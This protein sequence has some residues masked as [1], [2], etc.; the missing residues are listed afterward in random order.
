MKFSAKQQQ[1]LAWHSAD[2]LRFV[3][4]FIIQFMRISLLIFVFSFVGLQLLFGLTLKSQDIKATPV[5][6]GLNNEPIHKA[7]KRIEKQ[8]QFRF[9]YRKDDIK[10]M[11]ILSLPPAS[12]TV[13]QTLDEIFQQ[14]DFT[15]RQVE[16]NIL[17]E[18]KKTDQVAERRFTGKVFIENTKDPAMYVLVELLNKTDSALIGHGYTDTTG[19]YNI[20]AKQATAMILR[21]SGLGYQVYSRELRD[22]GERVNV[23]PVYLKPSINNLKEVTISSSKPL[24]QRKSDRFVVN[25][26]NS[27]LSINN[28]VWDVLKQVPLVN[29]DDNGSLSISAKQGAIVYINGRKSNLSGQA[30]FNYLKSLPST[31]L[32]DI[33]IVTTPGSEFDASGNAGILNI[34]FKKRES[35]GY[36]GSLALTDRQAT[37]NSQQVSGAF[38]YRQKSLGINVTPYLNRDRK[39]IAERH[40]FDFRGAATNQILNL[41]ALDR[42]EF[43][44]YYGGNLGVEYGIG[45]KQ[46]LAA[47]L[48]Y[49]PNHQTL[50]WINNNSFI[51]KTT[52]Q[53]DSSFVFTNNSKIKGHSLDAGLN[54]SFD[55]DTLGQSLT[56]SADYFEYSNNTNQRTYATV[57]ETNEVRRNEIAVLPQQIKNYT[58]ALDYKLPIGSQIKLKL[59]ARSFNTATENNLYY[60]VAN[61]SGIYVKDELRSTNYAYNEHI[62]AA[63]ASADFS[64]GKQWGLTTGLRLEQSST[65]GI[66]TTKNEVAVDKDYL[67]LFPTLAISYAPNTNHNFSYTLSK[68]IERPDFW[69]LN[70]LRVYHNPTQ[71]AEGNPFLQ[72]SYIL[73]N[74]LSY[75]LKGAYIFLLSHAHITNSFSQFLLANNNNNITRIVWLNYGTGNIADF[76]FIANFKMGRYIK[77]SLTLAGNY[78]RYKGQA[79]DEL[80]DNSGFSGSVKM[81]N[82]IILSQKGQFSAFVNLNYL[83]PVVA[84]IGEGS[85]GKARGDLGIGFRKTVRQFVFTL[86][87]A[88]LLKTSANKSIINSRYVI[89]NNNN[90]WDA[91]SV[92]FNIRYNFGNSKLKKNKPT[93]NAAQEIIQRTSI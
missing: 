87:G 21:V 71:Y 12:R 40:D 76:T 86:S 16:D 89:T 44:T 13:E 34:V 41:S 48:N 75:T 83:A 1:G 43:R 38:N 30:L 24:I 81:N 33:E 26:A 39:F 27:S 4:P 45:K 18:K 82:S 91:R 64:L 15:F 10:A 72:S 22:S 53:I 93:E 59:G 11:P 63:Y 85:R 29:A 62:N 90:Y 79:A 56:A 80:I 66:E 55:L 36:Q 78:T 42:D 67:N 20:S 77:S 54:Y 25:V 35:D 69:Q 5:T 19:T 8:T 57:V 51:D 32:S 2:S 73:K 47:T 70:N 17:I 50:N 68:R 9:F 3:P 31:T 88:D 46:V 6:V 74:E 37:Y 52:N 60:A 61:A 58:F 84:D 23:E 14:S 28:T 65:K 7:L 49:N 92:S